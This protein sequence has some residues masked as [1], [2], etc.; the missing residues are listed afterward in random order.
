MKIIC[1]H[2]NEILA[3]YVKSLCANI[4][5]DGDILFYQTNSVDEI[6]RICYSDD[7]V[8][9]IVLI[10]D[11]VYFPIKILRGMRV[12]KRYDRYNRIY[13][14]LITSIAISFDTNTRNCLVAILSPNDSKKTFEAVFNCLDPKQLV[15][16]RSVYKSIYPVEQEARAIAK[17]RDEKR[18][19]RFLNFL[20]NTGKEIELC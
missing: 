8:K 15:L 9:V 6:A 12:I 20:H 10:I 14:V 7:D 18:K 1:S 4:K 19:K 2:Y 3:D 13:L 11:T 16:T 5:T 17:Y